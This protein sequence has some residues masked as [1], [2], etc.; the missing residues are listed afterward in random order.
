MKTLFVK[1]AKSYIFLKN[2]DS[3]ECFDEAKPSI[4]SIKS[5]T[6]RISFPLNTVPDQLHPKVIY[7]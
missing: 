4:E 3:S 1:T 2:N 7:P 6:T 5:K